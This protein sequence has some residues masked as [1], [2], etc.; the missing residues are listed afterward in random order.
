MNF[1]TITPCKGYID[2]HKQ[3][4][5]DRVVSIQSVLPLVTWDGRNRRWIELVFDAVLGG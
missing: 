4:L 2:L 1:G 3:A 5:S